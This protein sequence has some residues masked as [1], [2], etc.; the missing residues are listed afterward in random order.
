M[1][2]YRSPQE[3]Y[4][5]NIKRLG[6]SIRSYREDTPGTLLRKEEL[7]FLYRI[8]FV[9]PHY[10]DES[11]EFLR[12]KRHFDRKWEGWSQEQIDAEDQAD[13]EPV[14]RRVQDQEEERKRPPKDKEEMNLKFFQWNY[15]WF[16]REEQEQLGRMQGFPE[17]NLFPAAKKDGIYYRNFEELSAATR[18]RPKN[19]KE[20]DH[21]LFLWKLVL[22]DKE[23]AE[24]ARL[25]GFDTDKRPDGLLVSRALPPPPPKTA[26]ARRGR[27]AT[28]NAP[29]SPSTR[30]ARPRRSALAR[31]VTPPDQGPGRASRRRTAQPE[32]G[33]AAPSA[34][35]TRAAPAPAPRKTARSRNTKL[36]QKPNT[37]HRRLS[38]DRVAK[39]PPRPRATA[40]GQHPVVSRSGRLSK[41]PERLG[42]TS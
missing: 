1:E 32:T 29:Q 41:A 8:R 12:R 25:Y 35:K 40:S 24:L 22:S 34:T 17:R 15:Q 18:P 16:T 33:T 28:K 9:P 23:L 5:A 31:Q 27:R 11:E 3:R 38:P 19:E 39:K 7:E 2:D 4:E 10:Y 37:L 42:F 30:A 26:S 36:V 14:Q 21:L 6:R 20:M 13:P